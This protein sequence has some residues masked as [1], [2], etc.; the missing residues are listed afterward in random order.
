MKAKKLLI[1]ALATG[2]LAAGLAV[3]AQAA[4]LYEH[5][6]YNEGKPKAAVMNVFNSIH[7]ASMS[8]KASSIRVSWN[9]RRTFYEDQEHRG[10]HFVSEGTSYNYL[11]G[12]SGHGLHWGE[13]WD[14]RITSVS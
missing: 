6:N 1:T 4:T 11:R 13:T 12:L 3:P 7:I 8:D 14:D 5:A 2:T 9:E 10:R